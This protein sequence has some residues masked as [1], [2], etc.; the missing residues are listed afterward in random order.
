MNHPVIK[1]TN[2]HKSYY[3]ATGEEI[4]VLKGINLEIKRNEFVALM[5]ES[6]GGKIHVA[7]YN[8]IFASALKR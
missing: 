1:L 5:G 2:A 6:G 4:P 7:K 8:W 3:L